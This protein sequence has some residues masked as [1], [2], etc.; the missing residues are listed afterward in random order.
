MTATNT[1]STTT[2]SAVAL[3]TGAGPTVQQVD[4]RTLLVDANVRRD[5]RVD[6]D[7]V[8]SVRDLGMLVPIV[9][10]RTAEG[11]LRVRFGHRRTLAAIDA[12]LPTVPVVV[13]ADEASDDAAEIER[14]VTQWAENEHRAGLSTAERIGVIAQ[15]AAFGLSPTQISKRT[16]AKRGGVTA[17]LAVAGSELAQAATVRYD[18]LDLT[19]AATVAEFEDDPEA[20]KA[21]VVAA[22][23]GQFDHTAQ[24]LLDARAEGAERQRVVDQLR[25]AGVTVI[26]RPVSGDP[27]TDLQRLTAP[28]GPS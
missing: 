12:A 23:G 28:A 5:A 2:G 20:V 24:R 7:L 6:T 18:F 13:A 26:D 10:V 17:A 19:Q 8:A 27:A 22:K 21:L 15:L 11:R 25:T 3:D 4:P 16:R 9:A 1:T 14:L